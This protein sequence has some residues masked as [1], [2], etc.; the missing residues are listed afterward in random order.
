VALQLGNCSNK[1]SVVSRNKFLVAFYCWCN[2]KNLTTQPALVKGLAILSYASQIHKTASST[3]IDF[4]NLVVG[5]K[6]SEFAATGFNVQAFFNGVLVRQQQNQNYI[7]RRKS[8][9]HV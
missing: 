8:Y 3:C 4:E 2:V 1:E 5:R 7:R 6:L 9:C